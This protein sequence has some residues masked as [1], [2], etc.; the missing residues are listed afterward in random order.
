[1]IHKIPNMLSLSRVLVSPV[2]FLLYISGKQSL[3]LWSVLLFTF[4]ALTDYFDGWLARKI[5]ATTAWGKFFDP[6]ADKFLTSAAFLA[7]ATLNIIP[8]WMVIIIIIR[9]F[10][11]TGLRLINIGNRVLTTSKTAKLKTLLQMIFI[12]VIL[13]LTALSPNLIPSTAEFCSNIV[14]STASYFTMLII[15]LIT[16]WSLI[17]YIWQM[18]F[19]SE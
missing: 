9:D 7:F 15:T 11:T 3:E 19:K 6:L 8:F 10:G 18:F 14:Y 5:K 13:L 12:F 4:G 1:M 2:F 17:E 16:V